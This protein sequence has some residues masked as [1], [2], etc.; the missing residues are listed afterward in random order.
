MKL[1]RLFSVRND[2]KKSKESQC[3]VL[4]TNVNA[5]F[6]RECRRN[7]SIEGKHVVTI[8][9][10]EDW[11]PSIAHKRTKKIRIAGSIWKYHNWTK[12]IGNS[13]VLRKSEY[14]CKLKENAVQR[15]D[16]FLAL[17]FYNSKYLSRSWYAYAHAIFILFV[18]IYR[19]LYVG[20]LYHVRLSGKRENEKRYSIFFYLSLSFGLYESSK[21]YT[22]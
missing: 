10:Q 1:S 13:F 5:Y 12:L 22:R 6:S 16:C 19:S 11:V 2:S 18:S 21:L 20:S 7:C 3:I 4:E 8:S 9:I 14:T 15:I 17:N